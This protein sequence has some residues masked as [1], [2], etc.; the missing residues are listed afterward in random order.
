MRLSDLVKD[1]K[2]ETS[3]PNSLKNIEIGGISD[4][5]REIRPGYLFVAVSGLEKDGHLFIGDAISNGAVAVFFEDKK[6]YD[7]QI[8]SLSI[9]RSIASFSV[10]SSRESLGLL[11]SNWFGRPSQKIKIVGVTGTDGKTT[12]ANLMY[13]I[14]RSARKKVGLISTINAKIGYREIDTG[15][16]VTSPPPRLL[17]SL[18]YEMVEEGLEYVVLEVTSHGVAQER[19]AGVD[20]L[21]AVI[22]NVTSEHLD[23]HKTYENYLETKS[24][25]FKKAHFCVLNIDDR[26]FKF[27]RAASGGKIITYS[28]DPKTKADFTASDVHLFTERPYFNLNI[29]SED[30]H[31][32]DRIGI[33]IPGIYNVS[34][35]LAAAATC[36]ELGVSLSDIQ[37]G[38][39]EFTGLPGRFERIKEGQDFNVIVDFAHTPNALQN[40]LS[41]VSSI[42]AQDSRLITV[43]GCAGERDRLKRPE[44][45]NISGKYSDLTIITAED[46]RRE[47]LADIIN[48]VV[49][50]CQKAG[51]VESEMKTALL[52]GPRSFI[53]EPDRASAIRMALGVAKKDDWIVICGK[54][55]EKSMC[56]GTKEYPWSDQEEVRKALSELG[57]NKIGNS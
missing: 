5:S 39:E 26:S 32:S 28:T 41:Y 14:L 20:F 37:K 10:T 2:V 46:P 40:V 27:L 47:N 57:Y 16:H 13:S 52:S 31:Q 17:H 56:F 19:I 34:N 44:M 7:K 53:K 55:H 51:A 49:E 11:W 36:F 4:D 24:R 22:T 6:V 18:L 33:Q 21:G 43:F 9:K 15:F 29:S 1:I 50:G 54:G 48:Q 3:F 35:S 8:A 25:L 30:F 38:I 23:Y 45:G 12:T 42:R